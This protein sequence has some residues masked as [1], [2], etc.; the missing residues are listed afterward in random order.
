MDFNGPHMGILQ[1]IKFSLMLS[2]A[3][4]IMCRRIGREPN[5]IFLDFRVDLEEYGCIYLCV[6]CAEAVARFIGYV[7]EDEHGL[8]NDAYNELSKVYVEQLV[9]TKNLEKILNARINTVSDS[10]HVLNGPDSLP[11]LKVEPKPIDPV[12]TANGDESKAIKSGTDY[13]HPLSI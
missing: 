4:C 2:P 11:I 9:I 1:P 6:D 8:V 10:E 7:S 13:G 12:E 3:Q 5:E